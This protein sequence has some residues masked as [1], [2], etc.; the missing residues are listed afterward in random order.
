MA[1]I[2]KKPK[3]PSKKQLEK[4]KE[5]IERIPGKKAGKHFGKLKWPMDGLKY[6]KMMRS[7]WS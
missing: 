6:Q 3:N 4:I 5:S 7:E 1:T 2:I